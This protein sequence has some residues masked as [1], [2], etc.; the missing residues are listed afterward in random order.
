MYDEWKVSPLLSYGSKRDKSYLVQRCVDG[1]ANY[2]IAEVTC[3][4]DRTDALETATLISASREMRD[5][6]QTAL[7]MIECLAMVTGYEGDAHFGTME[8]ISLA[9]KKAAVR[10]ED[11]KKED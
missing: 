4:T 6:L 11:I 10:K 5:A 3:W 7:H 9:L 1:H 8:Q 2:T